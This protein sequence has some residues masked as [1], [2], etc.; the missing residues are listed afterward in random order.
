MKDSLPQR[1]ALTRFLGTI[2]KSELL[3]GSELRALLEEAPRDCS[4]DAALFA[5]HLVQAGRLSCF[6]ARK[7]LEGTSKGL[8]LGPYHVLTP[9]GKGGMSRVYCRADHRCGML[10]ALKVLRPKKEDEERRHRARFLREMEL[11]QRVAHTHLAQTYEIG[12]NEGVYFIA[13]EFIPGKSLYRV[14]T[15]DGPLSVA[16][17]ARLF[18]EVAQAL[19]HAHERGLIHRDIKPSN[20]LITTRDQ[21]KLVDFGLAI[22]EGE[23]PSDHRVVGGRGYVVGTMD[24]IAPE[25]AQ[26]ATKV[27]PRSD[28]YSLGCTL[29]FALAGRPPFPGGTP[30][31]KMLRHCNEDPI[32]IT[33]LNPEVPAGFAALLKRM[34]AKQKEDRFGSARSL[35]RALRLWIN[36]GV[37]EGAQRV[38]RAG[39]ALSVRRMDDDGESRSRISKFRGRSIADSDVSL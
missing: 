21:A 9:I 1:T 18:A 38:R 6:Q 20:I 13:M 36:H 24:Y 37:P 14:V 16:R 33:R 2:L 23:A 39:P 32:A 4:S 30:L 19:D 15:D 25:Q 31:Q 22:M 8:V 34:M 11:C 26:D 12:V 3:T 35:R 29:Y 17:A 5:N 27:E 7:L 10:V 28:I